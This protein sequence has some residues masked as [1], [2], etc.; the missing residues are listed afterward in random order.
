MMLLT[1]RSVFAL[2]AGA[3][4]AGLAGPSTAAVLAKP[5]GK[6]ILR[7][8]GYITVRNDGDDAAFD[9]SMLD[10]L[11]TTSFATSTP[12]TDGVA[13]WEG[14]PL[15]RLMD[16]VGASGS[17]IRATALNDY[18]TDIPMKDLDKEGAILAFRRDGAPMP[19]NN[20]GPLF[21]LYPFDSDARLQ[22]QSVYM[23]CAWQ[24]A[25]LD[26]L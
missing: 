11:G 10:A 25:R 16:A 6:T 15:A 24:V 23:R 22:Q 21:V 3:T 5:P 26:V 19:V 9:V 18:V 4:L 7:V 12:W 1:R 17:L 20:K 14:V 2:A 13:T 8:G